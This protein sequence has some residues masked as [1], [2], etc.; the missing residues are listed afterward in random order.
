[1]SKPDP[2]KAS[3]IRRLTQS[4]PSEEH[5]RQ[6]D[7]SITRIM[8]KVEQYQQSLIEY[9]DV[10]DVVEAELMNIYNIEREAKP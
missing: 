10:Q 5:Q 3:L 6:I 7:R 2:A 8:R 9:S 4:P 1:M